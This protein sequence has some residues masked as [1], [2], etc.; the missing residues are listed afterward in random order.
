MDYDG[1]IAGSWRLNV[2]VTVQLNAS[3]LATFDIDFNRSDRIEVGH[4][5]AG[6]GFPFPSNCQII[7]QIKSSEI[8]T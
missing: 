5:N 3:E 6:L 2:H 8:S 7:G 4:G 1:N